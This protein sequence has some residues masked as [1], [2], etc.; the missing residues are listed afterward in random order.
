MRRSHGR[1]Q[2]S[3]RWA[4]KTLM[5]TGA[6]ST[7]AVAPTGSSCGHA[8]AGCSAGVWVSQKYPKPNGLLEGPT[9]PTS[10]RVGA[11]FAGRV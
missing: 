9:Q 3:L 11:G 7:A 5:A 10:W 4:T 8:I 6:A 1:P 2:I